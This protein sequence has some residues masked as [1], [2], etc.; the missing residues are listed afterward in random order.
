[1]ARFGVTFGCGGGFYRSLV[2]FKIL[3]ATLCFLTLE[4]VVGNLVLVA[5]LC[6]STLEF[7]V[8]F[9]FV[10]WISFLFFV[11]LYNG[12]FDLGFVAGFMVGLGSPIIFL[13]VLCVLLYGGYCDLGFGFVAGSMVWQPDNF[14]VS[15]SAVVIG[16]WVWVLLQGLWLDNMVILPCLSFHWLLLLGF[17]FC[18][19]IYGSKGQ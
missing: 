11:L 9:E 10:V 2:G 13:C 6:F 12:Y 17:G 5:V 3:P 14:V 7:V 1:M 15:C 19:K 4:F 16:N 18:C 8:C